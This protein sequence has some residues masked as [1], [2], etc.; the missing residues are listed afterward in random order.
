MSRIATMAQQILIQDTIRRTQ[1]RIFTRQEQVSS[2]EVAQTFSGLP[3]QARQLLG[4][5]SDKSKADSFITQNRLIESGLQIQD[6]ALS[7]MADLASTFRTIVLQRLNGA[8]GTA[9]NL[10]QNAQSMLDSLGGLLN[11][12]V[13][14]RYVF[15]GSQTTSP[16]VQVPIPDP[17]T[18]G[19]L[20]NN[21]Y[22]GDSV[23]LTARISK[24]QQVPY[25]MPGD[26][27]PFQQFV[28]A[29]KAAVNGDQTNSGA[30]LNTALNL[31]SSAIDGINA[32]RA[33]VGVAMNAI[34]RATQNHQDY[35]LYAEGFIGDIKNADIP[36]TMSLLTADQNAL[37]ASYTTIGRLSSLSLAN[38]LR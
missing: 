24:S 2:G 34:D 5:E 28:A 27:L 6:G 14:G 23:Q 38:F 33:N 12:Q 30:M 20:D 8:T 16:A 26:S 17:A 31:V 13:A 7:S 10:A 36:Q 35:S 22:L 4:L 19:V 32:S 3:D 25:T 9:S 15:G 37:Q 1:D 21:Y 18:F 29:L 11:T